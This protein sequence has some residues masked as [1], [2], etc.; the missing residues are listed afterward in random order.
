[1][2]ILYK[3]KKKKY[4]KAKKER[5]YILEGLKD[6]SYDFPFIMIEIRYNGKMKDQKTVLDC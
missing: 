4:K 3:K 2:R 5:K 1:M 6:P